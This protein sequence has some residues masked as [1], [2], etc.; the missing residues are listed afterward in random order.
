MG[1]QVKGWVPPEDAVES[2]VIEESGSSEG[3]PS[4]T[5][6]ADAIVSEPVKKKDQSVSSSDSSV[7][8]EPSGKSTTNIQLSDQQKQTL[9]KN[10]AP[11]TEQQ[12]LF[13]STQKTADERSA[14]EFVTG[15]KESKD[16][17]SSLTSTI[18]SGIV[19]QLPKE[20][21]TQRLRM[22]KGDFT[23]LYDKRSD[24]NAFGAD[25][26]TNKLPKGT[27]LNDF[28]EWNLK[29]PSAIS[30]KSINERAKIF[31][32]EKLGAKG[33]EDLKS[34]FA[35]K[36]V[37]QRLGF[38]KNIE[39]QNIEAGSKLKGVI[40]DLK[41]VNGAGDFLSF[42]G[43]MIGQAVY[44]APTSI[45]GGPT[46]S[47]ISESAAIYDR[48]LDLIAENESQK[49]GRPVT[50]AEVVERGLDKPAEGQALAV[51]AGS[52]DALSEFNLIGMFKKA[53][54]KQ[55]TQSMA[56]QF[57]KGFVR[58]AAPEVATEVAQGELEEFAASKGAGVEYH[59]DGW[60][61][62]TSAVGALIGGGAI[63]GL[64]TV[65]LSEHQQEQSAPELVKEQTENLSSTDTHFIEQAA[66]VIDKKVQGSPDDATVALE[67][68]KE[69]EPVSNVTIEHTLPTTKPEDNAIQEQ[70][71][72]E[73]LQRQPEETGSSGSERGRVE[74]SQ[75]GESTTG[76][77]GQEE[78]P[79]TQNE[80]TEENQI[81]DES[82]QQQKETEAGIGGT[83][84]GTEEQTQPS[85]GSEESSSNRGSGGN[86]KI[87]QGEDGGNGT[88]G[89]KE[90]NKKSL[91]N[92]AYKGATDEQVKAS[93]E[94]H[95]LNYEVESHVAAEKS[96]ANFIKDVGIDNAIEAVRKNE[97]DDGAAAFVWSKAIDDVGE[98][99]SK[100]SSPEEIKT[101]TDQQTA[102]IDEF[103][104][105]A[106]SGG[107]FISALQEV[108]RSSDFG[109]SKDYQVKKYKEVN[110]GKI[111]SEIE[112]KF[113]E[114]EKQLKEVNA[115]L[116][117]Y[118]ESQAKSKSKESVQNL[119]VDLQAQKEKRI[120][121]AAEKKA[122]ID[123]FF[124]SLKVKNEPGK[125][126]SI[127]QVIGEAVWNGSIEVMRKAVMAG[128][129]VAMAIQSGIDYI[130][131]HYRGDDFKEEDFRTMMQPG[132][133]QL[134]P[135]SEESKISKPKMKDGK[136]IIPS[137]MVRQLV[138]EGVD[139]IEDLT[140]SIHDLIKD[141]M[142]DVSLREVRDA[143]TKYGETRSLS[144]DEIN[145]KIRELKRVGKLVSALEDVQN[146]LRP[147]RSGVQRD[148]LT[149]QE[150]RMQREIKEAMKDLPV[151]EAEQAEAW[152]NALDAVKSRLKNSITDLE[153]QIKTGAKTPK[154][155]G[156]EYDQEAKDLK[157]QRDDLKKILEAT[158]GKQ[159]LS[160]EQKTRNAV[161]ATQ[162]AIDEYE[163][164]ISEKDF[165]VK[166]KSTTKETQELKDLR[167]ARDKLKFT[168]KQ[169]EKD[170]GVADK[171][172]L[173]NYK[174]A[175]KKS[176]SSYEDRIKKK[177]FTK[178]VKAKPLALDKEASDLKLERD[179]IKAQFDVEQEKV[180]LAN[181]PMSEKIWDTAVDVWNLPKSFLASIDMSAPFRQGA[182]LSAANPKA[183]GRSFVEMFKQAFSQKKAD[184]WLLKLKD[185]PEYQLMKQSKLYIAESNTKLTA[186]EEQF[187]SNL[188]SKIP[189]IG[190]LV[191]GSERAYSGYLNKLRVDVFANGVDRL[192]E[193]GI[194]PE[195]N[196]EAYK[197]WAS[198]INN[199]TGRGNLGALETSATVLNGFFFS[200]RYLASRVNLLNPV[201]YAKM[202]APV[203]KMA[204]K[205]ILA[206]AAFGTLVI[207]LA[208]AAG[209]D[210]EHDPRSS[211]FGKIKIGNTRYDLWAGFQ[212]II[213]LIAQLATGERKS[214]TTGEIIK[215][216]GKKFPFEDR[217]DVIKRF[218][219]SKLAPTA[220]TAVNLL[221]GKD[222][223][224]NEVTIQGE[225]IKNVIPLY[226]QD[227]AS[228]YKTEG[229]TVLIESMIPAFFGIGV[230]NYEAKK[231]GKK[232]KKQREDSL[233][234][235]Y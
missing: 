86:E 195:S 47:I 59:P 35:V 147:L 213:R 143:I 221:T 216:D 89:Q 83:V 20:Y 54:G 5:P 139:N 209:A 146:K 58:G 129:D 232:K 22:S 194:T 210:V 38:E 203:R 158:E 114:L 70:R 190:R 211:D 100:T 51:L 108:Y 56:K 149:D 191:K 121:L 27:S 64:S 113:T 137:A 152:K 105:K 53:A 15:E 193:Q 227:I 32:T 80:G 65:K 42:A 235:T 17:I 167:D 73:I 36:N 81:N 225:A 164:R 215:I 196:P 162:K 122:K 96:A 127:T 7:P 151:D 148:K 101:L 16:F 187:L 11:K 181:R 156:I 79:A 189:V 176:V 171:K 57:A 76:E 112:A 130:N 201:T 23:D 90:V 6:P 222:V 217:S 1:K 165:S 95:G 140:Q 161:N 40:Q 163:R 66:D 120:K 141:E 99:L 107:R 4:W 131:E 142:P 198:F 174:K 44:R 138:E 132:I 30:K 226:L 123:E 75:Q 133:E 230:Q 24:L 206:Y 160:D 87:R 220:S 118:E 3:T 37:E 71:T 111:S 197:A 28:T 177:D 39:E 21:Y 52:L 229:P 8:G 135:S 82:L 179:K 91:L 208:A 170:L 186:K 2:T 172:R 102:L 110:N 78:K 104:K 19:D 60:R 43:N 223:V 205:N 212:Q 233:G 85:E 157:Q 29:Q 45:V 175:I 50:R 94:K 185:S 200:P 188:A 173:E 69:E 128:A 180:R 84:Q 154:K 150:R 202:P 124:N 46:G 9:L 62:A 192:M 228:I 117:A 125:L 63:G 14:R 93:I 25:S 219:R 98:K 77:S 199:A 119:R 61:M 116:K 183:G 136:L 145:T 182:L 33:F 153:E 155:K 178:P 207:T 231:A 26:F 97:V 106:R 144:Q 31:L 88:E 109:Y 41:E 48:Q 92:R 168:Y 159:T 115:K 49:E 166:Q 214:T 72:E 10:T 13:E 67:K 34:Q 126:N 103:D 184:E 234:F 55:L 68:P 204:I 169:L 224:G 12:K 134:I 74:R 18:H 218:F